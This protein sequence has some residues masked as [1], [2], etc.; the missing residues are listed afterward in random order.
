M[1]LDAFEGHDELFDDFGFSGHKIE[2]EA[3]NLETSVTVNEKREASF[4]LSKKCKPAD[5]AELESKLKTP[6]HPTWVLSQNLSKY[7]QDVNFINSLKLKNE[8]SVI[9]NCSGENCVYGISTKHAL[10]AVLLD[11]S[12]GFN[13]K[14]SAPNGKNVSTT[15]SLLYR[16]CPRLMFGGQIEAE[17]AQIGDK[18]AGVFVKVADN[19]DAALV[20]QK[21]ESNL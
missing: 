17:G 18:E 10:K 16:W 20:L 21:S 9:P 19:L 3:G 4:A 12:L 1:L 11:E 7:V 2:V 5:G 8:L 14:I 15:T 6:W 13:L